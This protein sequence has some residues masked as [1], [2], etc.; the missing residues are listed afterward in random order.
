MIQDRAVPDRIEETLRQMLSDPS[1]A[2]REAA[3]AALDRIRAKRAVGSYLDRLKTAGLEERVRTVYAAEE[4]GGSEGVAILLAA[5]ADRETEVRGSAVRALEGFLTPPVLKALVG[6]LSGENGIVLANIVETLGKSHR[7]EL[8]PVIERYLDHPEGEIRG[9]SVVAY[10]RVAEGAWWD[11]ILPKAGDRA[12]TVR[13]AVA[14]ALG[15]W[16]A[17]G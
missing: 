9:K 14:R 12:E 6:R 17:P 1:A 10:A 11:R 3:G 8:A 15:E 4:I 13:A 2:V 16:S 7:K 5:L